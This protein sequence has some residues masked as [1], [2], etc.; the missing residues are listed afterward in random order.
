MAVSAV[1][2]L[3]DPEGVATSLTLLTEA[4]DLL[5]TLY[6][7]FLGSLEMQALNSVSVVAEDRRKGRRV[8]D[9]MGWEGRQKEE[10]RVGCLQVKSD[11]CARLQELAVLS[12]GRN[13]PKGL[14]LLMKARE[15]MQSL[16]K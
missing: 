15:A 5:L 9:M 3:R 6:K 16:N 13:G 14:P 8:V 7:A 1:T 2:A 10:R 4:C 11:V 12:I